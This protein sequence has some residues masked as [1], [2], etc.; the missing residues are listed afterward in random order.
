MTNLTDL[1]WSF[2]EIIFL[3]II[4]AGGFLITYLVLPNLIKFSSI[5]PITPTNKTVRRKVKVSLKNAGKNITNKIEVKVKPIIILS[6]RL[7]NLEDLV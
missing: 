3:L 2:M 6:L 4:F 5:K 1:N 7:L